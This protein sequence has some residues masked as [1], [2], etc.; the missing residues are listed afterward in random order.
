VNQLT[1]TADI[2]PLNGMPILSGFAVS[3]SG[4]VPLVT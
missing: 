1:S 2:D 3:I 4:P